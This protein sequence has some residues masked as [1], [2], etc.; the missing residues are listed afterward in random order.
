VERAAAC[1]EAKLLRCGRCRVACY[2]SA[3]HQR[4]DWPGAPSV[5][6]SE[7]T[8]VAHRPWCAMLAATLWEY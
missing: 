7:L 5:F 2:K 3:E 1:D 8:L 6:S 4:L